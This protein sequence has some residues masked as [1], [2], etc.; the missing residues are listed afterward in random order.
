MLLWEIVQISQKVTETRSRLEKT[1]LL[2]ACL[3]HLASEEILIGV[4]YLAE[5]FDSMQYR[6]WAGPH[7]CCLSTERRRKSLR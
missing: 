2:A 5:S 1:R 6:H 4:N 7:L 3:R